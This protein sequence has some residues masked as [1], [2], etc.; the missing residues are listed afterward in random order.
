MRVIQ[1]L[2]EKRSEF[3]EDESEVT[4]TIR[5]FLFK[6]EE[7]ISKQA[8]TTTFPITNENS[9]KATSPLIESKAQGSPSNM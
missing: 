7:T 6:M 3:E 9:R 5:R 1:M 2:K 4:I 8:T